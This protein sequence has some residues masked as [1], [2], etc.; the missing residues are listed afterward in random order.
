MKISEISIQCWN[1]FGIFKNLN[2]FS[3]NKLQ[4]PQ[5]IENTHK[6]HIFG[7]V[8]TM[9]T[10][11][12][13]DSLQV[14]G[15]K[16]FQ[17]CRK[18]RRF[19]R[20][21]GGIA[22]FVHKSILRG[23]S[24]IPTNGAE[25]ILLKLNKDHFNFSKDIV[26]SFTYCSPQNSS[27]L[28]RT[29]LD[30][31]EDFEQ[32]LNSIDNDT[33]IL[34][35]G[36][37]NART[38]VLPDYIEHE[39]NDD[40]P[41][42]QELYETDYQ[43]T[44]PRGNMDKVTN[45]YGQNLLDMCRTVPLR[46]CNGRKLGDI[47]GSFM[48]YKWNGQ[49]VVDY[50]LASPSLL[51][52]IATFQVGKFLPT[53]SDHCPISAK[54]KTNF[55]PSETYQ[56]CNYNFLQKPEKVNWDKI[57]EHTFKNI[58][59]SDQ[60]RHFVSNM[61][62]S[63]IM[64]DQ[65]CIDSA[66]DTLATFLV[67]TAKRAS[68]NENRIEYNCPRKKSSRNWKFKTK[69]KTVKYP[70]WHDKSCESL[71][72]QISLSSYLLTKSPKNSYLRGRLSLETKAYKKLVK[73]KQKEH[74]NKMFDELDSMQNSDP[75]GYMQLVKSLRKGSFDK[76]VPSDSDHVQ[77]DDWFNHFQ[78]LLGPKVSPN[79]EDK[80][81][82]DFIEQNCDNFATE[83]DRQCTKADFLEGV[84]SLKNNK[85]ASF[86]KI[87]N[88][89]LKAGSHFIAQ[90]VLKLFNKILES[91]LYPSAWKLDILTHLHKSGEKSD[92]NNFR[93]I[94]VS[95]CFGKLFNKMLQKRLEKMAQKRTS[96]VPLRGA[97]NRA[98]ELQTICWF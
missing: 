62:Q 90:P 63:G 23:V 67:Q 66:T 82:T 70:K 3:Y 80:T 17:V 77:P 39:D 28:A 19:G 12:D 48:C 78:S 73:S 8:E 11:D 10:A 94:S 96:S 71:K 51:N 88:E 65:G 95:S 87:T 59:R 97:V 22:V 53:L 92:T 9:H 52:K 24:K 54:L 57:S 38:G 13:V 68:C 58:L 6:H 42:P 64:S 1:I 76:N 18:K 35:L 86:D 5:L 27:Y 45:K 31:F 55:I 74:L 29:Q 47:Q 61:F 30:P 15:Y 37:L 93:G 4:D 84:S 79:T 50:C 89:I 25:S 21:H 36:D 41:I 14:L 83:L 81:M 34:V 20:K 98:Q 43:A 16:C 69:K 72:K 60:S 32:K 85:A 2:G 56:D 46:I 49:S 75:H 40:I 91:S 44:I 26:I 33:D 7:L